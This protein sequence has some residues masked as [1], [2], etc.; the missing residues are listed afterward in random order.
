MDQLDVLHREVESFGESMCMSPAALFEL[1]LALDELVTNILTHGFANGQGT[2]IQVHLLCTDE[3]IEVVIKDN[4][5]AYNPKKAEKPDTKCELAKR[6]VGGL[7]IYLAKK[8]MDTIEYTH[9]DGW[10]VLVLR[11]HYG[12]R[13]A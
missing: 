3:S 13:C 10:N 6:C 11:K 1:N 4:G 12:P 8:F 7:G 5:A 9:Q 2:C